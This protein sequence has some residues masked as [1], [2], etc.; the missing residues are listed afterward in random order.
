MNFKTALSVSSLAI[1][2]AASTLAVGPAAHA[3]FPPAPC[4]PSNSA[5]CMAYKVKNPR[6]LCPR[7]YRAV[8]ARYSLTR[9]ITCVK[10]GFV[11]IPNHT[12]AYNVTSVNYGTG[13]FKQA[14]GNQWT[15][16]N[17]FGT[18]TL[19]EIR[20]D[21]ST[22]YLKIPNRNIGYTLDLRRNQ[23]VLDDFGRRRVLYT[24]TQAY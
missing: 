22:I 5:R 11:P 4:L 14:R 23:V 18:F 21:A 16:K 24:I 1:F 13:V 19:Q 8:K 20:R 6:F 17:N 9:E 7:E 3:G 12:S 10:N 15:E 2:A